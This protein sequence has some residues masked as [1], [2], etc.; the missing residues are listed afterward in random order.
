MCNPQPPFSNQGHS[1]FRQHKTKDKHEIDRMTLTMNVDFPESMS[2]PMRSLLSGLLMRDVDARLGCR[3]RGSE[4]VKEHEFFK[5]IDWTAVY[6]QRYPPPLI[7]P[8]GEVNAADAFDIGS[9]D[10]EDTK[11]IK[12]TEQD[13]ALYKNF[14]LVVSEQWQQEIADT[15]FDAINQETDRIEQKKKQKRGKH[16]ESMIEDERESDCILQGF[17]RKLGGPVMLQA[18][19]VRYARLYPNR[20]ELLP[21]GASLTKTEFIPLENVAS[22]EPELVSVR[23]EQCVVINK[24]TDKPA[25]EKYVL[26][27]FDKDEISLRMWKEALGEALDSHF[28]R[29]SSMGKASK[30]YGGNNLG[31]L[32]LG[33]Q[34]TPA[35]SIS[36]INDFSPT[37]MSANLLLTASGSSVIDPEGSSNSE[38]GER[39]AGEG[40]SGGGV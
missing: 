1:P 30:L 37:E 32:S 27:S 10:E 18:W 40:S 36:S 6:N 5:G 39:V 23:N 26:A 7:P 25:G 19:S 35:T 17:L 24:V 3:G 16:A 38:K 13:Q 11:G 33:V 31:G 8:R 2:K 34:H 29:M 14:P 4:E 22:V 20:L 28:I 21:D 15:V 12:L 9:F